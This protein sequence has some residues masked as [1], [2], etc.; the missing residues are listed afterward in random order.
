[1]E[2]GQPRIECNYKRFNEASESDQYVLVHHEYAGLSGF[3]T[4][5]TDDSDYKISNQLTGFLES[6]VIKKLSVKKNFVGA[7]F[8]LFK[9][10]LKHYRRWLEESYSSQEGIKDRLVFAHNDVSLSQC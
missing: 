5:K 1:M 9:E 2:A 7:D 10:A 6:Q 4:N 3:E 8:K